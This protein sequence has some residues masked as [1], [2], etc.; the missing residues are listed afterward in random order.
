MAAKLSR[1][2]F[3]KRF[4]LAGAGLLAGGLAFEASQLN[5][6]EVVETAVSIP[7][8]PSEFQNYRIAFLTDLHLGVFISDSLIDQAV[9]LAIAAKPDL[10]LLGGDYIWVQEA[11][12]A[13]I[14][15]ST[16]SS[17]YTSGNKLPIIKNIF[18]NVARLAKRLSPPDGI[19]AVLGNHDRWTSPSLCVSAF[20]NQ[21][22]RVLVNEV[23]TI[24][25]DQSKIEL[26]GIDD[27]W[28]GFP[29]MPFKTW[30]AHNS[31]IRLLLSH[32]PD[33]PSEL[34]NRGIGF[35]LALCG[36]THGGQV[37]LPLLGALIK[38]V[39]DLRFFQGLVEVNSS[40]VYTSR[41]I[42]M[43]EIPVRLN[44]PSEVSVLSLV[45]A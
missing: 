40:Q 37:Q 27:Y 45:R 3:L 31:K 12:W 25:R 10:V 4:G 16:A 42:G 18:G 24:V 7:N 33:Y 22:V 9:S 1:R 34:I 8:L 20:Q 38:N 5:G 13:N 44:C 35:E 29:E 41:G 39:Y 23:V 43:V 6:M 15:G 19:F 17:Q 36:H 28:T 21:G 30:E 32:N 2:E 26:L 14:Y 11:A